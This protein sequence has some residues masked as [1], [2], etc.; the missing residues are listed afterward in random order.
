MRVKL[1]GL[2]QEALQPQGQILAPHQRRANASA[3][4][5]VPVEPEVIGNTHESL[6]SASIR[7]TNLGS[8]SVKPAKREKADGAITLIEKENASGPQDSKLELPVRARRKKS[9]QRSAGVGRVVMLVQQIG[10]HA[11]SVSRGAHNNGTG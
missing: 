10:C 3:Q 2:K 4:A 11:I 5:V 1:P 8:R 7:M 6:A 9:N